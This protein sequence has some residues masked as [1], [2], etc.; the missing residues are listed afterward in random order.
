MNTAPNAT[1]LLNADHLEAWDD[2]IIQ[3]EDT[4]D[5]SYIGPS[6]PEGMTLP[7][8]V[9]HLRRKAYQQRRK[10]E[11]QAERDALLA[12]YLVIIDQI[13]AW[14]QDQTDDCD[15]RISFHD[16]WLIA[17]ARL[18]P[19]TS[20]KTLKLPGG[21][22]SYRESDKWV[23][24]DEAK[25]TSILACCRADLVRVKEEPDKAALKKEAR[26][27]DGKV[28]VADDSGELHEIPVTVTLETT[29][30]VELE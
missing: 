12:P 7:E 6:Q 14:A 8:A 19:P 15:R 26:I 3:G 18:N 2:N 16:N 23:Y 20:G 10:G 9:G 11:I 22:V 25:L 27:V 5:G 29:Y 1:G 17:Y 13:K 28:F 4:T 30:K 24:T 21:R